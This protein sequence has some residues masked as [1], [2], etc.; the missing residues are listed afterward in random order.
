MKTDSAASEYDAIGSVTAAAN[1]AAT[2]ASKALPP[3]S[4]MPIPAMEVR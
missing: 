3:P 4:S 2:R 1:P